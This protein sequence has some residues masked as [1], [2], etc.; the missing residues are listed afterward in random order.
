MFAIMKYK[1]PKPNHAIVRLNVHLPQHQTVLFTERQL[2][3]ALAHNEQTT[4]TAWFNLNVNDPEVRQYIYHDI[5]S[6]YIFNKS[7]GIWLAK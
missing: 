4:L 2:Q 1:L 3:E 5:P 7:R 6:H